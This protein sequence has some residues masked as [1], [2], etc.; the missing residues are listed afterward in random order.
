MTRKI[1]PDDLPPKKRTL[2]QQQRFNCAT[3]RAQEIAQDRHKRLERER[4]EAVE[5]HVDNEGYE[6]HGS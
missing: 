2:K 6:I 3:R 4:A 1:R 5:P